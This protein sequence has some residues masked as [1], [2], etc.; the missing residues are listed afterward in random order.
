MISR[1]SWFEGRNVASLCWSVAGA[2]FIPLILIGTA[3][4]VDLLVHRAQVQAPPEEW[5]AF[6]A[7]DLAPSPEGDVGLWGTAWRFRGAFGWGW[8]KD[9]C[10]RIEAL[11][12]GSGALSSVILAGIAVVFIHVV[13]RTQSVVQAAVSAREAARLLRTAVYRQTL[14]L[15]PSDLTGKRFETAQRLFTD[16]T[17]RVRDAISQW[18]WRWIRGATNV[19][20]LVGSM[21]AMDWRLS[22]QCVVPAAACWWVTR[23]ER[24]RAAEQRRL[25]ESRA[26]TE[27]RFLAEGLKN[28]RLIRGYHMEEFEQ[29]LFSKHLER[30]TTETGAGRRLERVALTTARLLAVAAIGLIVLLIGLRVIAPVGAIPLSLATALGLAIGWL[31]VEISSLVKIGDARSTLDLAGDRIYRYLDEIP[32]VGQAVG[33]K[34]VEPVSKSITLEKVN[35]RTGGVEILSGVELKLPAKTQTA[36][37]SLDPGVPRTAAYLLPRFIEPTAGRV[38]FDGQD[39]AWGTLES[40]RAETLYIGGEDVLL[41]GTVLDN[42]ICGDERYSAEDATEAAKA[43]HAHSFIVRLPEG[44]ETVLGEHGIQLDPGQM[45]R[46]GLARAVLRNPAVMIIEE[47]NALLDD[48]TKAMIDDAYQR[49]SL[50]RTIIFLPTRLSTIRRCDQVVLFHEGKVEAIGSHSELRK[51]SDLY[52]HWDYITFNVYRRANSHPAPV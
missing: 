40:I 29:K 21:L 14:R 22:L 39:I 15:G 16:E 43:V 33:A 37:V 10:S 44:Y 30:L 17:E 25:A 32:E 1:R 42:I 6:F 19:P 9:V 51:S 35:Y 28:S 7:T 18:R 34:F 24:N 52:R 23:F 49:M 3:L 11:R 45:F 38:L 27:L 50:D 31:M 36:L 20:V 4:L 48:D 12:T 13:C 5:T 26:E 8:L 2:V 41:S 47:P 46:I